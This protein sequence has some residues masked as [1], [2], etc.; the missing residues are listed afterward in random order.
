MTRAEAEAIVVEAEQLPKATLKADA[1]AQHI[2][3]TYAVRQKLGITTIGACDASKRKRTMLRKQKNRMAKEQKRRERG[4]R[5][6]ENSLEKQR[7]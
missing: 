6:H 3:L 4:A 2:G 5:C 1:L 7:P